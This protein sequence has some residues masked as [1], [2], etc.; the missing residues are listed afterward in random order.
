[1]AAS[2]FTFL[3]PPSTKAP[4]S[5]ICKKTKKNNTNRLQKNIR[6]TLGF[7]QTKVFIRQAYIRPVWGIVLPVTRFLQP[8]VNCHDM[9]PC[10][11]QLAIII[12]F[13][14]M[15]NAFTWCCVAL[16]STEKQLSTFVLLLS[17]LINQI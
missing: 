2:F 12:S 10:K 4:V 5:F 17:L 3:Q 1:M 9:C 16:I 7:P 11:P 8:L 14:L 13:L 6:L 15:I